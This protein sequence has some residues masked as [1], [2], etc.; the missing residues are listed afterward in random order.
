MC[1]RLVG[2]TPRGAPQTF[3]RLVWR[4][5]DHQEGRS[6]C[7]RPAPPR[8]T[9]LSAAAEYRREARP[10]RHRHGDRA[11]RHPPD[12]LQ[13]A[14]RRPAALDQGRH[15]PHRHPAN[16]STSCCPAPPM[17]S[18]PD[19][20][21]GPRGTGTRPDHSDATSKYRQSTEWA[22]PPAGQLL[23]RCADGVGCQEVTAQLEAAHVARYVDGDHD[24]ADRLFAAAQRWADA[25][26]H[27]RTSAS[28]ALEE[29]A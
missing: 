19:E 8:S 23:V 29:S 1:V 18:P 27:G 9:R 13:V 17:R 5:A 20:G 11:R 14:R 3:Q 6:A 24:Q 2:A 15:P 4:R 22:S 10:Q 16:P 28:P 12:D 21:A 7:H 26:G 25:H